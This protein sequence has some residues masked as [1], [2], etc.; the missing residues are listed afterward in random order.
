MLMLRYTLMKIIFLKLLL[1]C[2]LDIVFITRG[3]TLNMRRKII[4]LE[5]GGPKVQIFLEEVME[6]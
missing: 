1:S 4:S 6:V 5:G 3:T 2:T